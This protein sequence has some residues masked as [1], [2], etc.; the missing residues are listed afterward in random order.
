MSRRSQ[1]ISE[2]NKIRNNLAVE[3]NAKVA[4]IKQIQ[5]EL[6]EEQKQRMR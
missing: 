6:E 5:K 3:Q 1:K 2:I 4:L